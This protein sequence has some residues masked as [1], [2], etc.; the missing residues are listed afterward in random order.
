MNAIRVHQFTAAIGPRDAVSHHTFEVDTLLRDL[1]YETEIF[2]QHSHPD[3]RDRVHD[4]RLH[5]DLEADVLLYQASTGSRVGDYVLTRTEPLIVNYHNLTPA[6]MFDPWEPHVG[7]ELDA[8]RRQLGRLARKA[9][10]GLADS[11]FNAA[12][13]EAAGLGDVVVAPVL[14]DPPPLRRSA[15]IDVGEPPTVLF[16]GRLSPN[17]CQEDLIAATAALREWIPDVR[18]KLVGGTSSHRYETALREHAQRV[19]PGGVEFAG[20][21]SETQLADSY[22]HADVFLCLSEH[23][24]F[25][26]PVIE[27]MAAGTPV[28]A[29]AAAVLPE[30]IGNAG[31]LLE[32]KSPTNVAVALE[33]VLTDRE[34]RAWLVEK[35]R[36]RAAT[37]SPERNRAIMREALRAAVEVCV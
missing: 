7:A 34:L 37:F 21:V 14:F 8:G 23:E 20:S 25:C 19:C 31:I 10:R 32:D 33:R 26:V 35:G 1:G 3:L 2:A 4:Y 36:A 5:A 12:E 9:L 22:A 24:G 30:T 28:V 18:L 11:H 17:K 29:F 27:A 15:S 16:V 6:E 13:L